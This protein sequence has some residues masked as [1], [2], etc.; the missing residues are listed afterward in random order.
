LRRRSVLS[1]H[2]VKSICLTSCSDTSRRNFRGEHSS[3]LSVQA[4]VPVLPAVCTL[5]ENFSTF[6]RLLA[7]PP[8]NSVSNPMKLKYYSS[9]LLG[10]NM[11]TF[12]TSFSG[13]VRFR[14]LVPR[15]RLLNVLRSAPCDASRFTSPLELNLCVCLVSPARAGKPVV[16]PR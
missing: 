4:K 16:C 12:C 11:H 3:M 2:F 15:I 8:S 14:V 9:V 13:V 5:L 7:A 10:T 1:K 6:R